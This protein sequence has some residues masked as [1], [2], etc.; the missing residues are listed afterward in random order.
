MHTVAQYKIVDDQNIGAGFQMGLRLFGS[1]AAKPAYA[2]YRLPIWVSGKGA[3]LTVYGQVRPAANGT[4][5]VRRHPER[6]VARARP[7]RP[8]R[9]S[10]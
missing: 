1:N 3:T 4:R 7:S 9:R 5:A 6:R 8:C 10:R 2:A